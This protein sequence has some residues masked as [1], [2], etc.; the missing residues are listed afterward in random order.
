MSPGDIKLS[1]CAH[2]IT[3]LKNLV[4]LLKE[5]PELC[6]KLQD[7]RLSQFESQNLSVNLQLEHRRKYKITSR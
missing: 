7:E 4:E 3:V 6:I 1:L 5:A 2:G